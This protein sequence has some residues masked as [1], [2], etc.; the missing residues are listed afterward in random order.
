MRVIEMG[1]VGKKGQHPDLQLSMWSYQEG[2]IKTKYSSASASVF[3]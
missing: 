1:I 2:S 3:V